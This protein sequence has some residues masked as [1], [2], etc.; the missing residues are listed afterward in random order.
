MFYIQPKSLLPII[1]TLVLASCALPKTDTHYVSEERP[2][3]VL[4]VTSPTAT[5]GVETPV[6][7]TTT[8]N[9]LGNCPYDIK[10]ASEKLVAESQK[11][12]NNFAGNVWLNTELS[13]AITQSERLAEDQRCTSL[14]T[15]YQLPQ[16]IDQG[17]QS[18]GVGQQRIDATLERAQKL[19]EMTS[20]W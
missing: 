17:K 13:L 14:A 5:T 1:S 8:A 16:L 6:E 18:L 11:V 12:L 4:A 2:G 10:G 7:S 15:T 3:Q 20:H 19:R 9:P